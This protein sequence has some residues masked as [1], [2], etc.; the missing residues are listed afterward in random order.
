MKHDLMYGILFCLSDSGKWKDAC[1]LAD[2]FPVEGFSPEKFEQ[3]L[4]A[5]IKAGYAL[6]TT[7]RSI[8]PLDAEPIYMIS[9]SGKAFINSIV[10]QR[11][12]LKEGKP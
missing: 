11:L 10:R 2:E 6:A 12:G 9:E 5:A 3:E 4:T 8:K 1:E 7:R